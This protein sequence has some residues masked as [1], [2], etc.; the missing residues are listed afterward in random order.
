MDKHSIF[1]DGVRTLMLKDHL[2]TDGERILSVLAH[3]YDVD[4]SC[5]LDHPAKILGQ[6]GN[7]YA[8]FQLEDRI[9]RLVLP[10]WIVWK[11]SSEQWQAT[12]SRLTH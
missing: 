7:F 9:G 5:L 8:A 3:A 2:L 4:P 10:N 11:S 12:G 1:L 6:A